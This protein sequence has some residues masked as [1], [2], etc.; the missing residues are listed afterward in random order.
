MKG[1]RD[2]G[3]W[4]NYRSL[5]LFNILTKSNADSIRRFL[6]FPSFLCPVQPRCLHPRQRP[7]SLL[8]ASARSSTS[9][10]VCYG[11]CDSNEFMLECQIKTRCVWGWG[12]KPREGQMFECLTVS[13]A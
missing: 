2:L 1:G 5:T 11:D 10:H 4:R 8:L 12:D 6:P 13:V 7:V 9:C 3:R